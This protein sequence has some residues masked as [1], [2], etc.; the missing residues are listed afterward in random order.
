MMALVRSQTSS[1]R[2][3][4]S[5]GQVFP[6]KV[7]LVKVRANS[8]SGKNVQHLRAVFHARCILRKADLKSILEQRI[9]QRIR[10]PKPLA[11]RTKTFFGIQ[12]F[13]MEVYASVRLS[14]HDS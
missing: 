8:S 12:S 7:S 5:D 9:W 11:D 3:P 13:E 1:D 10:G 14:G 4:H 6:P 2:Q